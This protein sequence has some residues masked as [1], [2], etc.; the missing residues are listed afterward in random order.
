MAL[1]L[2]LA[3]VG[4]ATL[5]GL[6]DWRGSWVLVSVCGVVQD[7]V[8]KLTPGAPVYISFLVVIFYGVLVLSARREL[9]ADIS[10]FS[11]RFGNIYTSMAVVFFTLCVAAMNGIFSYGLAL[12]KVPLL[13][14]ITYV[15]PVVAAGFGY[16]WLRREE[17]LYSFFRVYS[18]IT[19]IGLVGTTL[20]YLRVHWRILGLVSYE[21]DYIR[22][23]P[24]IQIRLLSGVYRSPDVMAWHASMLTSIAVA[25]ALRSGFGRQMM[26]WSGVAAWGFF[27]CMIGGR[28]KAIYFVVVFAGVFLFRYIKRVRTAQVFALLAVLLVLG[29]VVR[30]LARGEDTS[31]YA[32]GALTTQKELASR[33]EGGLVETF[34]QFGFMGAGLGAATQGV[35]HLLENE[36]IGWQEG[37]LGKLAVEVGLPGMLAMLV[38]GW[39]VVRLWLRLTALGDVPGS[40]QFLRAMLL[41]LVAAN[42][43]GFIVSAQ[44][45]TDAVLAL[46]TGFLVGCLFAT[47]TLD[48]RLQEKTA[49]SRR[50]P[51]SLTQGPAVARVAPTPGA[52]PSAP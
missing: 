49:V 24:G 37:G 17:A 36:N 33:L 20:E 32:K 50:I 38:M 13:S 23:L 41:G 7:P 40:S 16:C 30:Q 10:D 12:W 34:Q 45:Y 18:V 11:R 21:G 9:I 19:A 35:Y 43:T 27:N 22:H 51:G 39:Y 15:V 46:M 5:Y 1:A 2:Y 28:R 26:V 42:I 3:V 14:M 48:E 47:A 31:V 44:A 25:M 4:I 6:L 8:R 29:F 52:L